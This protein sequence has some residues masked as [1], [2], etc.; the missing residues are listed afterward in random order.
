MDSTREPELQAFP[1]AAGPVP[2]GSFAAL[3]LAILAA[4]W[5]AEAGVN[6]AVDPRDDFPWQAL[7]PLTLDTAQAKLPG[8]AKQAA[9]RPTLVI[10]SSTAILYDPAQASPGAPSFNLALSNLLPEDLPHLSAWLRDHGVAPPRIILFLDAYMFSWD[11]PAGA[12]PRIAPREPPVAALAVGAGATAVT[13]GYFDDTLRSLRFAATEY[14]PT[15][16]VFD[17]HG[18]AIREPYFGQE[19]EISPAQ[20]DAQRLA[21]VRT[22][23]QRTLDQPLVDGR[24][25]IVATFV[26]EWAASGADVVVVLQPLSPEAFTGDREAAAQVTAT[27]GQVQ[28]WLL[29]LCGPRTTVHDFSDASEVGLA[30][31][32]FFDAF[33]FTREGHAEVLRQLHAGQ[34]LACPAGAAADAD[35]PPVGPSVD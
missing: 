26:A 1:L 22:H 17:E 16:Y 3:V 21:R 35:P 32:D 12:E 33:H 27:L 7:P 31:T 15:A 9:Q 18:G 11:R 23:M 4:A 28:A 34:R 24:M 25:G 6:A 30:P 29:G 2:S 19:D 10:G 20:R 5:V 13:P 8:L 14:P